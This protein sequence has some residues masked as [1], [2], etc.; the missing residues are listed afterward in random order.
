MTWR[1][2]WKLA[3]FIIIIIDLKFGIVKPEGD[4]DHLIKSS[5][6]AKKD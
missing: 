6:F 3:I 2:I 5:L 4:N 1:R